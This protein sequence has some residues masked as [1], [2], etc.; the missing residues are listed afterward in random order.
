MGRQS[1]HHFIAAT[2]LAGFTEDGSK[3][4]Q[5]WCIPKNNSDPFITNPTD[6]CKKRDYYTFDGEDSLIVENWYANK[7]EPKI[8]EGLLHIESTRQLPTSQQKYNLLLLA[9]TLRLRVPAQR[10]SFET[11]LKHTETIVN[12]ICKNTNISNRTDFDFSQNTVLQVEVNALDSIVKHLENKYWR[13]YVADTSNFDVITSDNPFILTH[14]NRN[15]D[16]H[17]GINTPG[18]EII[19]PINRSTILLGRNEKISEGTF[20]AD[21]KL[22]GL[23]NMKLVLHTDKYFYSRKEN[24]ALVDDNFN[25]HS[26]TVKL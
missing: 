26:Q 12:D 21:D 24:F 5:F 4:S 7:I 11:A 13:L 2:Y 16:F 9:A 18:T 1:G 17:F 19:V 14:P 25:V 6:S 3:Q 8:K 22:I 20:I 23:T 15:K 10:R